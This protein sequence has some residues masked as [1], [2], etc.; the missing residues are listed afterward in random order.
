MKCIR[1]R[2]DRQVRPGW[3]LCQSCADCLVYGR[4]PHCATPEPSGRPGA[5][6]ALVRDTTGWSELE[7][8]WASGDR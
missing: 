8:R 2:C 5:S 3:T 1:V 7:K 4:A 6:T